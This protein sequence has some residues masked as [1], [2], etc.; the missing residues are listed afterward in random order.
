ALKSD[1]VDSNEPR[2]V[3]GSNRKGRN[4][5]LDSRACRQHR[6]RAH[7][8]ELL[9]EHPAHRAHMILE[10]DMARELGRISQD[11][12]VTNDA[13]VRDMHIVHRENMIADAR[14]HPAAFSAAM[15]GAELANQVIVANLDDRGL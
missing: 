14:H 5:E 13:V 15:N 11:A 4:V 3:P 1:L 6:V 2:P 7:P 12:V 10:H 9:Y 8:G